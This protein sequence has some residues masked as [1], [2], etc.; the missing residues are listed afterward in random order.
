MVDLGNAFGTRRRAPHH[1]ASSRQ[2]APDR[3][4]KK[5][6]RI[7][8][9]ADGPQDR[10]QRRTVAEIGENIGNPHDQEQHRQ[11]VDKILRRGPEFR[12]QYR[13]AKNGNA[14]MPF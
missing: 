1:E 9:K 3:R 5:Y 6:P 11:F 8:R 13:A 2:P 14:S 10:T 7:D 12:Q 4:Q